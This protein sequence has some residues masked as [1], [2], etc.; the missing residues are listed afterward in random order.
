MYMVNTESY[1]DRSTRRANRA[2]WKQSQCVASGQITAQPTYHGFSSQSL[3]RTA[4][5]LSHSQQSSVSI[6]SGS[7]SSIA[8]SLATS[9]PTGMKR[10]FALSCAKI[11]HFSFV[12]STFNWRTQWARRRAPCRHFPQH[13]PPEV[14]QHLLILVRALVKV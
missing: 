5:S 10:R 9:G 2:A 7:V 3:N 1:V 11:K 12:C 13:P 6:S 8:S 14:V 4:S